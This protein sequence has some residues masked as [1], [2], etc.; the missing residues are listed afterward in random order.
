MHHSNLFC[1]FLKT[2][3]SCTAL[4]C[5]TDDP[6]LTWSDRAEIF[7]I[8]ASNYPPEVVLGI[9]IS[10]HPIRIYRVLNSKN[11]VLARTFRYFFSKKKE[12][13]IFEKAQ[14]YLWDI[15]VGIPKKIFSSIGQ[16][17]IGVYRGKL[18]IR[19]FQKTPENFRKASRKIFSSNTC[20]VFLGVLYV[21][22]ISARSAEPSWRS[23][24]QQKE[25]GVPLKTLSL[26]SLWD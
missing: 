17:L 11:P 3:F 7:T 21:V 8:D 10:D 19:D 23:R 25:G 18:E 22:K 12:S 13:E 15:V 4:N 2:S 24:N 20:L 5:A 1:F 16:N 14:N 9:F 26:Q 6:P